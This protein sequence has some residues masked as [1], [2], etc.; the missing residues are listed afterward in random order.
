MKIVE[1][2]VFEVYQYILN[3][4]D[5]LLEDPTQQGELPRIVRLYLKRH[6]SPISSLP[7]F[8][9]SSYPRIRD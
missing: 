4:P 6:A 3:S 8:S 5:T 9:V 1:K 7:S 2:M